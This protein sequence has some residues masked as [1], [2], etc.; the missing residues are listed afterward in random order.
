MRAFLDLLSN[1]YGGVEKY[2]KRHVGLTDEDISIIRQNLI[3][4]RDDT[5][6]PETRHLLD[7]M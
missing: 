6:G 4:S 3:I 7:G 2:L 1:S 5:L